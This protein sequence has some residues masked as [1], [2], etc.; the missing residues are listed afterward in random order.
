MVWLSEEWERSPEREARRREAE[1]L[2]AFWI[3]LWVAW[4]KDRHRPRG[5]P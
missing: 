1:A 2:L 5:G 4:F 3:L